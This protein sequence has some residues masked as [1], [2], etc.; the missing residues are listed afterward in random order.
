MSYPSFS[1]QTL[2]PFSIDN[3]TF[4]LSAKGFLGV[5]NKTE[6]IIIQNTSY[7]L[8]S[9][10]DQ[11]R[12]PI[13]EFLT[14]AGIL[15]MLVG[16]SI[17][18]FIQQNQGK[19]VPQT[20][21]VQF[22]DILRPELGPYSG[23]YTVR[24]ISGKLGHK[25]IEYHGEKG[26]GFAY[27]LE[28]QTWVFSMDN[29]NPCGNII[30]T[31]SRTKAFDITETGEDV[32][33]ASTLD[34]RLFPMNPFYL[35]IGC[36][37]DSACGGEGH[38][39]C[40]NQDC[41][42]NPGYYGRR[43][44]YAEESTCAHIEA[45][46]E[47]EGE[48]V[49]VGDRV[50]PTKY[51]ILLDSSGV[52]VA[53]DGHSVFFSEHG[54]ITDVVV[55]TGVRWMIVASDDGMVGYNGTTSVDIAK[56][57]QDP[58]YHPNTHLKNIAFA[59]YPIAFNSPGDGATPASLE[60][61]RTSGDELEDL[62]LLA[63]IEAIFICGSCNNETNPCKHEGVCMDEGVCKCKHGTTG[64]LCEEIPT[65][66]AL[67]DTFFNKESFQY[68]DGD[69][70]QH[71]CGSE[72]GS[73]GI[74]SVDG[75]SGGFAIGFPQC[76]VKKSCE[77]DATSCWIP[78]AENVQM[79]SDAEMPEL[80]LSANAHTL[81]VA[82]PGLDT[83]RV[84]DQ[85]DHQWV[86]RGNTLEF[87]SKGEYA[88]VTGFW[89][90]HAPIISRALGLLPAV[91]AISVD[92]DVSSSIQV[93]ESVPGDSVAWKVLAELE[94]I[95]ISTRCLS[96]IDVGKSGPLVTIAFS[97]SLGVLVF[98]KGEDD[99]E[100]IGIGSVAASVYDLSV[101]GLSLATLSSDSTTIEIR[102][103]ENFFNSTRTIDLGSKL[104]NVFG[105]SVGGKEM[106]VLGNDESGV[107]MALLFQND[108]LVS[109]EAMPIANPATA[110]LSPDG[111]TVVA[112]AGP[113]LVVQSELNA[114]TK[115][116][117]H[118]HL[119]ISGGATFSAARRSIVT[120]EGS[121]VRTLSTMPRCAEGFVYFRMSL[122]LDEIPSSI[123]WSLHPKNAQESPLMECS[124]CYSDD[125]EY[126]RVNL[127][128]EGCIPDSMSQCLQFRI[129]SNLVE[130]S[131]RHGIRF[132]A[133]V[134]D[135]SFV[136]YKGD[137]SQPVVE[138]TGC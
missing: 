45:P 76:L 132:A 49:L 90:P 29:Q 92:T 94:D 131:I 100:F 63:E 67:C 41:V 84:F 69:C 72:D 20:L 46:G 75:V 40:V 18:I 6:A 59:S 52:P 9:P 11:K 89:S 102:S 126:I 37:T 97:S 66:D 86:Q 34:G 64:A 31:S 35:D 54:Q 3:V 61:Y 68:D 21:Y 104:K 65:G 119:T 12:A 93:L 114:I 60:W 83:V 134:D 81:V 78:R 107:T 99:N 74:G 32:W 27:C 129:E 122:H 127:I 128:E 16:G 138:E 14:L 123:S 17:F 55:Y 136:S 124:N 13:R 22:D 70:C 103:T 62:S 15:F 109:E 133:F 5:K 43:C 111:Q 58:H 135:A 50:Y 7:M 51:D 105:I 79:L 36:L 120:T 112:D 28:T 82:E 116:W 117:S 26:S 24:T 44:D 85:I 98:N 33:Y 130:G 113:D 96:S 118:T 2:D 8:A 1:N 57:F 77:I 42:C 121:E 53:V 10:K 91:L 73:C 48:E 30:A 115:Q 125:V 87:L 19:Y 56:F 137:L 47:E 101:D 110:Q 108:I 106:T 71:T 38:G 95:C 25:R 39:K 88:R 23:V 4:L 80:T